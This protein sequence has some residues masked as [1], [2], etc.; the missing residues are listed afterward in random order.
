[1]DRY[2]EDEWM[3]ILYWHHA[4]WGIVYRV[5][6]EINRYCDGDGMNYSWAVY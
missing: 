5:T 6:C 1:V 3:S 2:L 4:K